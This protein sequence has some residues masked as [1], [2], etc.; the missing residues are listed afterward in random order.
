L[1]LSTATRATKGRSIFRTLPKLRPGSRWPDPCQPWERFSVVGFGRFLARISD[2][3]LLESID[4]RI[5]IPVFLNGVT[6]LGP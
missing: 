3:F 1:F 4:C 2:E 6:R 5:Q